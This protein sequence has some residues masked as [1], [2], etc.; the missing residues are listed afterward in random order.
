MDA[1]ITEIAPQIFRISTYVK[2]AD[3]QFAQFLV[4]DDEPLLFHTGLRRMFPGVRE[5]VAT[6]IDPAHLRWIAFSHF[7]ADECGALNDWLAVAP[8]ASPACSA[9]GAI[10]SV[11]DFADRPATP[12]GDDQVFST[13]TH[14]FRFLQTPHLPHAWE[15]GLLFEET[16]G[17]LL[18]SD[19]F[20]QGGDPEPVT[21]QD[22]T[23]R[24]RDV[25]RRYQQSPLANY[26]P[27]TPMTDPLMERLARLAPKCCATMHGSAYVGD[28]ARALR[29]LAAVIKEAFGAPR[30]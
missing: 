16:S 24:T 13:G 20:H 8:H 15:S 19:L 10:V 25:I 5:A 29:S 14:R 1:K 11:D 17:T 18:C 12:L 27:Y 6:L 23:G 28:G 9:V 7:E 30:A 3:L 22:V 26:L 21:D 4:R 2:P